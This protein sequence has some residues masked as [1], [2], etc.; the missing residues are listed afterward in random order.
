[1]SNGSQSHQPQQ[2]KIEFTSINMDRGGIVLDIAL[3]LA[4]ELQ[5][6]IVLTKEPWR[7]EHMKSLPFFD[8]YLPYVTTETCPRAITYTRMIYLIS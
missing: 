3:A 4:C 2:H 1:M 8:R 6:D 7:S 5:L